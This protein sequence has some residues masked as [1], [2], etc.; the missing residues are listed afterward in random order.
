MTNKILTFI[1]FSY[2]GILLTYLVYSKNSNDSYFIKYIMQELTIACF[3]HGYEGNLY[4]NNNSHNINN[5]D[6]NIDVIIANHTSR[7]DDIMLIV[8]ALHKFNISNYNFIYDKGN[9]HSIPGLGLILKS[10]LDI[11]IDK[12]Y[13]KDYYTIINGL[14]KI[15]KS[16]KKEFI[17]IFP[18]GRIITNDKLA[19]DQSFSKENNIPIYNNLLC[20]K[21]KGVFLIIEYLKHLKRFGNLWDFTLYNNKNNYYIDINKVDIK[22][23]N[24]NDF[25]LQFYK[26]W[27]EKDNLL[28]NNKYR[29]NYNKIFFRNNYTI[30]LIL[31]IITIVQSIML[32]KFKYLVLFMYKI[33][34]YY[35]F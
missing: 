14:D 24:Y 32:C 27:E 34:Y 16:K 17:I 19:K 30:L 1:L 20:P 33:I 9:L 12:N 21:T 10:S 8:I 23:K 3:K 29:D 4:L 15:N 7:F 26:K 31:I 35:I 11:G 13:N 25:K 22:Y 5:N 28:G 18:E 2:I 6:N